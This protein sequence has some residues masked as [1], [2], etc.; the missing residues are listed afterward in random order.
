[1]KMYYDKEHKDMLVGDKNSI[2]TAM[3]MVALQPILHRWWGKAMIGF[4]P[5][6]KIENGIRLRFRWLLTRVVVIRES[7]RSV[8]IEIDAV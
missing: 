8:S 4:E 6:E 5:I 7:P 1:M 2:D 3:N